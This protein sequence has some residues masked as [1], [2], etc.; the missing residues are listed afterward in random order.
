MRA[1]HCGK[2]EGF[3]VAQRPSGSCLLHCA[4]LLLC[5]RMLPL[6]RQCR[7]ACAAL[8]VFTPWQTADK[9]KIRKGACAADHK[10]A[11]R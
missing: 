10:S 3:L 9:G 11:L 1:A 4:P 7:A 5:S 8:V 6:V 2:P